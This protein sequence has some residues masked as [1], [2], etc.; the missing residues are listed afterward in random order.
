[1]CFNIYKYLE[2]I[3]EKYIT[4]TTVT[5]FIPCFQKEHTKSTKELN[6]KQTE[7][8]G[9]NR[10]KFSIQYWKIWKTFTYNLSHEIKPGHAPMCIDVQHCNDA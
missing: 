7:I 5:Q 1:M 6:I 9:L 8:K 4:Q 3:I 2:T 10:W